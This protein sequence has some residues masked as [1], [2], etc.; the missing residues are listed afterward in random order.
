MKTLLGWVLS[1][2]AWDT[3]LEQDVSS[4]T[5]EPRHDERGPSIVA[6]SDMPHIKRT[7]SCASGTVAHIK[8]LSV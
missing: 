6:E 1:P 8:G 2:W 3:H 7:K 5:G 4:G